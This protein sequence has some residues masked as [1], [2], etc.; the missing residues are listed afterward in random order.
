MGDLSWLWRLGWVLGWLEPIRGLS[1]KVSV[2]PTVS[3][4]R[5]A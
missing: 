1:A 4:E 2:E 5:G 3:G